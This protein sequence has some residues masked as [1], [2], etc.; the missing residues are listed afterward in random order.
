MKAAYESGNWLTPAIKLAS[1]LISKFPASM[2]EMLFCAYKLHN[3][4]YFVI[5]TDWNKHWKQSI[6]NVYISYFSFLAVFILR[7]SFSSVQASPVVQLVRICLQWGRTGFNPWVGKIPWRR[8]RLPTPVFW[9]GEFHGLC[10]PWG[11]K[12]WTQLREFHTHSLSSVQSLSHVQ[13]FVIPWTA[14]LQPSLS[15]TNSRSLLKLMST[16]SVMP[17]NHLILCCPFLPPSVFPRTRV[18]SRESVLCIRWPS[19]GISVSASVLPM[20]I[21]DWFPLGWTGGISLQS[22]GLSRVF[23]STTVQKHQF[24]SFQFSAFFIIQL[25]HPYMTSGKNIAL[26]RQT[27]VGKV[28]S[29]LFNMLSRLVIAFLSRSK[30]ILISW[31][32]SP[33]AVTLEPAK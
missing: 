3:L 33:S 17:S 29:L 25:S 32:K 16:E 22:E 14:A 31:L 11:H 8:E 28:M 23:S 19:T 21:Q 2:W 12:E 13:L 1:D 20:N 10:S 24:F 4:W 18:F 5:A 7:Q 30:H 6:Y 26:T 9:P 15:I 27:F